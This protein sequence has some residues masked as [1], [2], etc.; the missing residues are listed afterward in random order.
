MYP[1][2]KGVRKRPL[3]CYGRGPHKNEERFMGVLYYNLLYNQVSLGEAL[4]AQGRGV[5]GLVGTVDD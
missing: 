4:E 2:G 5:D 1:G 3:V